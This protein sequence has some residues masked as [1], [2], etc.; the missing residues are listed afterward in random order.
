MWPFPPP[1]GPVP[2]TRKQIQEHARQ[3]RQRDEQYRAKLPPAPFS[4]QD[5]RQHYKTTPKASPW[6]DLALA[7]VIGIAIAAL[8]FFWWS[9]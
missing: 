6:L 8:L 7:T 5:M 2:W 3:Q 1:G 9:A 4:G